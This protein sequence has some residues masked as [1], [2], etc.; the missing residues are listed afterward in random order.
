MLLEYTLNDKVVL[1]LVLV[2][3]LLQSE[4]VYERR[5]NAASQHDVCTILDKT[6]SHAFLKV[7]VNECSKK[8]VYDEDDRS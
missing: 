4:E 8:G 7:V 3:H 1:S 5:A 6:Q 2:N